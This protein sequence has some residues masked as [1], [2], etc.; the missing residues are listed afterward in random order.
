MPA[1][2][3]RQ[4]FQ[5]LLR[6]RRQEHSKHRVKTLKK[7]LLAFSIFAFLAA[8]DSSEDRAE[9]HY[10]TA[11]TLLEEGDVPRALIE[12]RNVFDLNGQHKEARRLYA[13]TVLEQ[14]KVKEAYG[15][16]LLLSEQF[17]GDLEANRQLARLAFQSGANAQAGKFV[18]TVLAAEPDNL[19]MQSM[20]A[21]L[22]YYTSSGSDQADQRLE[23]LTKARSLVEEDP[24]LI[25]A[26]QVVIAQLMQ[27][28]DWPAL[29][30]EVDAA[31]EQQP[32]SM[33]L[34]RLRLMA[35][36]Q[37]GEDKALEE[38]LLAMTKQ[39]PNDGN[40]GQMLIR[41][42][43]SRQDLDAAEDWLRSRIDPQ[44]PDPR[45]RLM[46]LEFLSRLRSEQDALD[47]ITKVQSQTPAPRD[48]AANEGV[49]TALRA[50]LMFN[51]GERR[52][53]MLRLEDL[54]E[55]SEPGQQLD[56]V[57]ISLAQMREKTGNNV[58][59]RAL[60]EEV[61]E[62]DRTQ[63]GALK[64]K[65]GWLI[66]GDETGE[67][68]N[69]LR[70][71]LN[72]TPDDPEVLTLLARAYEREGSRELMIDMLT[73]AVEA[74]RRAPAETLRLATVLVQ[75]GQYRSAEDVLIEAL[76]IA[77]TNVQ[78]LYQLGQVHIAMDDWGRVEQDV[79]RLRSIGT[80]P[81][82][83]AAD[84]L[85]AKL[86]LSQRKTDAL[87]A[88]VEERMGEGSSAETNM[89]RA[90]VMT[91]QID[92]ALERA[93]AFYDK[94]PE[95]PAAQFFY[96]SALTYSEQDDEALPIFEKMVAAD[97]TLG[98]AWNSIYAIHMRA[99]EKDEALKA[100]E[101][102]QEA[103]PED[104]S[105]KWLRAG[106]YEAIGEPET[107]ID[108]YEKMYEENSNV[109]VIANNLASLLS[110]VRD[111][112]ESLERAYTVARRLRDVDVPAFQ[113]TYG[114]IA[115]RRGELEE[116]ERHLLKAAE[117]LPNDPSVQYHTGALLA[118][119][120]KVSEAR[121]KFERSKTLI[122]EGGKAYPGLAEEVTA[123]LNK[124][125]AAAESTDQ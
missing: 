102:A 2:E 120:N 46:L 57:K 74:S 99:D 45:P 118:A 83:A 106:H 13:E 14:G 24:S 20:N 109:P 78:L 97:P 49:F 122:E 81:A 117:A 107:A 80:T 59:A 66:E 26:R 11:L 100:L 114:W 19:E 52:A 50:G 86:L 112:A 23:A 47:E 25:Y 89:I 61:L 55:T 77:N 79:N 113:D 22:T 111:D 73:R 95:N 125:D 75:D 92:Q 53:A 31:L 51:M 84:E 93:K 65:A 108:I 27:D 105:L 42:Y 72:Q 62:H 67:A 69:T 116:A 10:Q 35:L 48:V 18:D 5:A 4:G 17:P 41:W 64:M 9:E 110:T 87:M 85:E 68:V 104:P 36:E 56:Q 71:A 38:T 54:I 82:T 3:A 7:I 33:Q 119:Q 88:F 60:V 115:L 15:Q 21:L 121:E 124:L 37:M 34:Y 6:S 1:R 123:A 43:I 39:F 40:V 91:G 70:E 94:E 63:V 32:E 16:F 30:T 44:S 29:L 28:R 90:L 98:A 8:C 96:A 76:R 103:R 12:L 58:G 101:S